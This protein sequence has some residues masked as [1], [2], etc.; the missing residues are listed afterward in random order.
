MSSAAAF[1][2][3]LLVG[4][5]GLAPLVASAAAQNVNFDEFTS[6]PVS[7]CFNTTGITGAL[8]YPGVLVDG[9][10]SGAVMNGDGWLDA[11]TSGANLY[12][13]LG[14]TISLQF[15]QSSSDI[16]L[17]VI[18]GTSSVAYTV[19]LYDVHASLIDASTQ[20]LA[21]FDQPNFTTGV[22]HFMFADDGV[23]SVVI[24]TP[25][26]ADGNDFAIDTLGFGTDTGTTPVPEPSSA[27]L[28][29]AGIASLFVSARRRRNVA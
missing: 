2:V 10:A 13:T 20:T 4:L 26:V 23:W 24:S 19:S 11:Q 3:V 18:N 15:H 22:A 25:F 5:A 28:L 29:L 1:R 7:C 9:G 6:P 21:A 14:A 17:D 12:G 8:D 16:S 27:L